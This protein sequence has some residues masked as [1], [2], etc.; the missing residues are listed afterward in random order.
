MKDLHK[1]EDEQLWTLKHQ[2]DAEVKR[3]QVIAEA[4]E[5]AARLAREYQDA[6]GRRPGDEWIQPTGAHDAYPAGIVV[7][8]AGKSWV[9]LAPANVWEPGASGWREQVT[10]SPEESEP[11]I[12]E[13][14]QPTGAHD[15]YQVGDQVA[16]EG[17][18]YASLISSNVWSP[19]AYPQGW[20]SA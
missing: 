5:K 15:A 11:E 14:V 13:W 19:A 4:A 8:H 3:R 20:R 1:I 10:K 2:I 9:S 6:I 12:P 16:F 7:T 17:K 18:V